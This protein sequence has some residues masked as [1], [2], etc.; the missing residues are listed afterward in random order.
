M[1]R[2]LD[3]IYVIEL[4]LFFGFLELLPLL[5][6][7]MEYQYWICNQLVL[8]PFLEYVKSMLFL[9]PELHLHLVVHQRM[10]SMR[11]LHSKPNVNFNLAVP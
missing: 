10:D 1:K 9:G 3:V 8:F 6:H 5:H 11:Q 7:H 2:I 4:H